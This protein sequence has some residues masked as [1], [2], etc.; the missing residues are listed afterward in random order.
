M[1]EALREEDFKTLKFEA[2]SLKSG[3]GNIGAHKFSSL[4]QSL[5]VFESTDDIHKAAQLIEDL[6]AEYDKI[7][8]EVKIILAQHP[9]QV[10]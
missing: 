6:F 10:A 7:T 4:C 8:L 3:S 2:H 9:I 1:Q 5:E